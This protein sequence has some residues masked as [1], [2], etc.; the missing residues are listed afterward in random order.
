MEDKIKIERVLIV[1]AD[2]DNDP[3]DIENSLAELEEL[4]KAA[5]GEVISKVIQRIDKINSSLFIGSGKVEEIKKYCEELDIPT[6]VFNDELSG[7]QIRNL[8]EKTNK[9]IVDRTNLILDIFA[10]R[11]RKS[12]V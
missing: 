4:V 10:L 7:A 8:E 11:D 6:I 5:G 12:V 1:G 3:V 9:K 2:Y